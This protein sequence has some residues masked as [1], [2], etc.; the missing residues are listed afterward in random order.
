MSEP[1]R[2]TKSGMSRSPSGRAGASQMIPWPAVYWAWCFQSLLGHAKLD[3]TEIY[4]Q[5]SLAKLKEVHAATHPARLH[6]G[7]QKPPG[8]ANAAPV[9]PRPTDPA[10][11]LLQ[12]LHDEGDEDS[13]S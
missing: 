12:A 4:T 2:L 9:R 11:A 1:G 7:P 8:A 3:T 5:V 6:R 10:G 13:I